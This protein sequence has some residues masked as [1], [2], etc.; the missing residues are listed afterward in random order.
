MG[1]SFQNDMPE[2]QR[3]RAFL[4][5]TPQMAAMPEAL[6]ETVLERSVLQ[7]YASGESIFN[8]GDP[9]GGI[10]AVVEGAVAVN[11][12]QAERGPFFAHFGRPGFWFGEGSALNDQ[13][14]QVSIVAT[15]DTTTLHL[16]LPTIR[17]MAVAEPEIWRW[18]GSLALYHLN[19]TMGAIVDL[20][21][22]D[23]ADRTIAVLLRLADRRS[24]GGPDGPVTID[25]SQEDLA[26]MTNLSRNAVGTILR[27]LE[28]DE[29]VRIG[30]RQIALMSP[31]ALRARLH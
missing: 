4:A 30:Y 19:V 8:I 11:L 10:Y 14:R 13:Q 28:A 2:S 26:A 29:M 24:P 16:P 7:R 6:R 27:R 15:R 5:S 31:D 25:A 22:R 1:N 3:A 18:I 21:I 12:G 17:V 9:P 20:M 23:P